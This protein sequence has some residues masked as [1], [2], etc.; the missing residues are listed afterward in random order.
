MRRR[1]AS[2]AA[3]V[4]HDPLQHGEPGFQL[5]EFSINADELVLEPGNF[6]GR[7]TRLVIRCCGR[8]ESFIGFGEHRHADMDA[9][10]ES[11]MQ[12]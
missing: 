2:V 8:F 6:F 12:D 7:L 4:A 10:R 5:R 9:R 11:S 3:I 1:T